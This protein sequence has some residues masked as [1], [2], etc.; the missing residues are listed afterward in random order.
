MTDN[1]VSFHNVILSSQDVP[2]RE[3]VEVAGIEPA[4]CE[5]SYGVA[6]GEADFLNRHPT[7]M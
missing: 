1:L 6:S 5:C 2:Q 3:I 4:R 7:Q